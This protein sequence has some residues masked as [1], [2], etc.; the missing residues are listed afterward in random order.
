MLVHLKELVLRASA[1]A[2][3][4]AD[5]AV[6]AA[7]TADAAVAAAAAFSIC[8]YSILKLPESL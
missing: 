2:G 7:T 1:A 8:E 5:A 6:A 4:A 3:A